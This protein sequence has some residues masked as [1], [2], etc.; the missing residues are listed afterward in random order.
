MGLNLQHKKRCPSTHTAGQ[1]QPCQE[2]PFW[3][4]D[5]KTSPE[6]HHSE[7]K[8]PSA[9]AGKGQAPNYAQSFSTLG[10]VKNRKVLG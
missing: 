1:G 2:H 7:Q 10:R 6:L 5:S 4:H 9:G 3:L 8:Q